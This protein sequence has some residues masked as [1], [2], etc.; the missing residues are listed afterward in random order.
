MGCCQTK[1]Q[2]S[3]NFLLDSKRRQKLYGL[4]IENLDE[5]WKSQSFKEFLSRYYRDNPGKLLNLVDKKRQS[6]VPNSYIDTWNLWKNRDPNLSKLPNLPYPSQLENPYYPDIFT[7]MLDIQLYAPM[8]LCSWGESNIPRRHHREHFNTVKDFYL[9]Q[10]VNHYKQFGTLDNYVNI[11][12]DANEY[13]K[14]MKRL[15]NTYSNVI[16]DNISNR[17]III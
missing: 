17:K 7:E 3:R 16:P 5:F 13:H 12:L 2:Y 8:N 6:P 10:T 9:K 4:S 15:Q 11:L 14:L 1:P